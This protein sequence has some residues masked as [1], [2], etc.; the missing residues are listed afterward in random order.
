[1]NGGITFE[2][3]GTVACLWLSSMIV[4]GVIQTIIEWIRER[5]G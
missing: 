1:M 4:V 2:E 5:R 3:L